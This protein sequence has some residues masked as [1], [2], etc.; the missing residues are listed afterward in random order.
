[1]KSIGQKKKRKT[2]EI[3]KCLEIKFPFHS[4]TSCE[5]MKKVVGKTSFE[6]HSNIPLC[7]QYG[8]YLKCFVKQN[9][10]RALEV[11]KKNH[12]TPLDDTD[13][14]NDDTD[15]CPF[16]DGFNRCRQRFLDF[17]KNLFLI[18]SATH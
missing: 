17:F 10:L 3:D 12:Q 2:E 14:Q 11:S 9:F 8:T 15:F 6:P 5:K 7:C 1:M 18:R 4:F 13:F 16:L